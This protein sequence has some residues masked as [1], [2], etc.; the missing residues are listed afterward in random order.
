MKII[1]FFLFALLVSIL[2]SFCSASSKTM[3]GVV[4][5]KTI[6]RTG[7][8]LMVDVK[9][10]AMGLPVSDAD[11]QKAQVDKNVKFKIIICPSGRYNI[12]LQ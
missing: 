2:V 10:K 6:L 7:N 9:G 3:R 4:T 5:E 1:Q 12:K 11:Y 8:Y